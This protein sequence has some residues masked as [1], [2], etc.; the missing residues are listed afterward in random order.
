MK[1]PELVRHAKLFAKVE[2]LIA[3]IRFRAHARRGLLA[4]LAFT[5]GVLGVA[6]IN[7]AAYEALKLT[8]GPVRTP[9]AIGIADLLLAGVASIM[10]IRARPGAELAVAEEMRKAVTA[11]LDAD[12]HSVSQVQNLLSASLEARTAQLLI[13]AISAIIG[14]LRKKR[15]A[16]S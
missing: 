3:E 16:R 10:A 13:P 9:L 2:L 1:L 15:Q 6:M 8:W 4:A 5:L 14:A 11:E 12:L 7:I